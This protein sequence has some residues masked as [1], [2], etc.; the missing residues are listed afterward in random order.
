MCPALPGAE[1]Y[2]A[3]A[4]PAALSRQRACPPCRA[5]FPA[6]RATASGS[7]VH[8]TPIGQGGTQLY[9]GSLATATPQAFTVASPASAVNQPAELTAHPTGGHA[10]HTGPYPPGFEPAHVLRGVSH[11]FAHAVPS[12][13]DSRTQP[14]WQC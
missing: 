11:W 13:L 5:G 1:Y 10:L 12:G 9:P 14:I 4:P 6:A 8:C 7:H 2:G 3:S